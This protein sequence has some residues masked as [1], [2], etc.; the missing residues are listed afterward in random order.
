MIFI[1]YRLIRTLFA[2]YTLAIIARALLPVLGLSYAHPVMR[3]LYTI[4][5]PLLAPIRRRLP[6]TGPVDFSPL[7]LI[8][9]LWLV[10]QI[11]VW[12]LF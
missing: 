7:V 3:F 11:L 12:V 8:L 1:L 10:E 2:L 6:Y 4:T 9:L 5:E